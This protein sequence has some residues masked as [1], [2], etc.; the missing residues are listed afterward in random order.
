MTIFPTKSL[1]SPVNDRTGTH[2]SL[3]ELTMTTDWPRTNSKKPRK[4]RGLKKSIG[5]PGLLKTPLETSIL[6]ERVSN[7]A[8]TQTN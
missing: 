3:K 4:H 7:G 5:P 2:K 6:A 8:N 1:D